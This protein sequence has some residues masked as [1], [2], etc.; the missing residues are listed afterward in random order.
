MY[1]SFTENCEMYYISGSL[2]I[3]GN[4]ALLLLYQVGRK[5]LNKTFIYNSGCL[6]VIPG[7]CLIHLMLCDCDI[8][9][10]CLLLL[11]ILKLLRRE[12][13]EWK[14]LDFSCGAQSEWSRNPCWGV[15][16]NCLRDQEAHGRW[17]RCQQ[18]CRQWWKDCCGSQQLAGCLS[19]DC[20]ACGMLFE[21]QL[22]GCHS[23]DNC[24]ST[25]ACT[26][27]DFAIVHALLTV[28]RSIHTYTI[29]NYFC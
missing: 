21:G 24:L 1:Q 14:F 12:T 18:T 2:I 23:K 29:I 5:K 3:K 17:R 28:F 13:I 9:N 4:T 6:A 27:V 22:A 26:S 7:F 25:S 20:F 16:R 15:S 10:K 19:R 11:C 8:E